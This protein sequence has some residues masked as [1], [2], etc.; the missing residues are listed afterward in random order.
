MNRNDPENREDRPHLPGA[1]RPQ[2]FDGSDQ[3]FLRLGNTPVA[4]AV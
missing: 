4:L 2:R 3:G 1:W